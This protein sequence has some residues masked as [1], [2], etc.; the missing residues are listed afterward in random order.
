MAQN[1]HDRLDDSVNAPDGAEKQK[2]DSGVIAKIKTGT[3]TATLALA[4]AVGATPPAVA[5]VSSAK[6]Y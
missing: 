1:T 4:L 5:E 6:G 2:S 3:A